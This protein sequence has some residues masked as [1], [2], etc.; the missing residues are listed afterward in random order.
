MTTQQIIRAW[1]D[2]SFRSD[3]TDAE[4]DV[5]PAHPSGGNFKELDE[6]ELQR[7]VGAKELPSCW[8]MTEPTTSCGHIC[9]FTTECPVWSVCGCP[10]P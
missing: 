1:K 2:P 3:L 9:T 5:L 7:V 6:A 10:S 8:F 4:L